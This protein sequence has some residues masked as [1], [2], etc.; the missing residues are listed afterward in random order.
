MNIF[1]INFIYNLIVIILYILIG[2]L[3]IPVYKNRIQSLHVLFTLYSEFKNSQVCLILWLFCMPSE[4]W[5]IRF[6]NLY[7]VMPKQPLKQYMY[8]KV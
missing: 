4:I 7:S 1:E 5:A 8:A 6:L 2:I 3:D